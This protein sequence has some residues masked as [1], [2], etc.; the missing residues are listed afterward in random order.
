MNIKFAI[1]SFI[2]IGALIL[3]DV[4][5][6]HAQ[7]T[8]TGAN[9][10]TYW[11]SK[12]AIGTTTYGSSSNDWTNDKG[13]G[14]GY[15]NRKASAAFQVTASQSVTMPV[16]LDE[17]TAWIET[18]TVYW[19]AWITD[20]NNNFVLVGQLDV[21]YTFGNKTLGELQKNIILAIPASTTNITRTLR[22][23]C[24]FALSTSTPTAPG[25]CDTYSTGEVED[26]TINIT[27]T[28]ANPCSQDVTPPTIAGCPSNQTLTTAGTTVIASWTPPTATDACTAATLSV[29]SSP[30]AGLTSG[31][32][33]PIG[34]TNITIT[35]KDVALNTSA[36]CSFTITVSANNPCSPDVT[37]PTL[38]GC[39]SNIT[40]TTTGITA[41]ASWTTPTATDNCT[42]AVNQLV[43]SSPTAN[44]TSGSAF[45]IGPTNITITAKDVALNTSTTSC[46]FTVTVSSG[47]TGTACNQWNG[48]C[49][50]ISN[51]SRTGKVAI[52]TAN[53]GSVVGYNLF[54]AGGIRTE[55]VKVDVASANGWADYVFDKKYKLKPLT[56]VKQF[57]DKNAHLPNMPSAQEVKKEGLDVAEMMT[58]QQ[59]KIEELFLYMIE[60]NKTVAKQQIEIDRLK[61]ENAK[62]IKK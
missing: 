41:I 56:E 33:F 13:Q 3:I 8:S 14:T 39:P 21:N 54:V 32:A 10:N 62:L 55:K 15:T 17:P 40:L 42:G 58:K 24:K 37:P 22:V 50:L 61:T 47:N 23:G 7:C 53:F 35:A 4:T 29:V 27:G 2:I 12:V 19:R 57:I 30:T 48:N 45:P 9:S 28:A 46:T 51:I 5:K 49:D 20:A 44:L 52:G 43:V 18:G 16:Q 60:L 6:S 1:L 34:P 38:T 59:E 11:I 26:Y 25:A 36:P 31:S